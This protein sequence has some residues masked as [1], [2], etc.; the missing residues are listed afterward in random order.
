[1]TIGI[2]DTKANNLNSL[3][4]ALNSINASVKIVKEYDEL[5]KCDKL[6]LPGIGSFDSAMKIL[7]PIVQDLKKIV[8][9]DKKP[10][11]GICLGMQLFSV[12][13]EEGTLKGLGFIN[14]KVKKINSNEI[15]KV[16][17]IGF[18]YVNEKKYYFSHSYFLEV[19]EE[20]CEIDYVIYNMKIPAIIKK[21][22]ILACQFH[23][24]ISGDLGLDFLK[25]FV[26]EFK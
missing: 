12:S 24:E 16:P 5:E 23:P 7:K 13:S 21:E 2:I 20:N 15:Y 22:N 1:M 10:I 9:E 14:A 4:N 8:L 26:E 25:Y 17:H 11:L 6:I 18:N 19:K 3:F